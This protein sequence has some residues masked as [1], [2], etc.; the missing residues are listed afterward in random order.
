MVRVTNAPTSFSGEREFE[1]AEAADWDQSYTATFSRL[2]GVR[3]ASL[4]LSCVNLALSDEG[5]SCFGGARACHSRDT[6]GAY[7]NKRVRV[8]EVG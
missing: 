8:W 7:K 4:L 5:G 2:Y 1:A 3:P 6:N